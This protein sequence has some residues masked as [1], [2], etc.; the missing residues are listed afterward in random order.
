[1]FLPLVCADTAVAQQTAVEPNMQDVERIVSLDL[2]IVAC[3]NKLR[4]DG[5]RF[6][7]AQND[8]RQILA[9]YGEKALTIYEKRREH[10]MQ[11]LLRAMNPDESR[12]C[13]LAALRVEDFYPGKDNPI[14]GLNEAAP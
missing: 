3:S 7:R 14:V 4:I 6:M 2:A 5:F 13:K 10:G 11:E 8:W 1:M 12:G 9:Q